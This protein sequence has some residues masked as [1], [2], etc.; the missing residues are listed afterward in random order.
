MRLLLVEDDPMLGDGVSA[1]LGQA[2]FGV[3]WARDVET[4][5]LALKSHHYDGLVLDLGLPDGSGL[6]LLKS[7]RAQNDPIPV[8]ILT[9]RDTLADRVRGLDAGSDDYLVK[10]FELGELTAR[11]R[12]LLRRAHRRA[13]PVLCH[14]EIVVDPATRIVTLHGAP[15]ELPAKEYT[16]LL[17]LL[18]NRGRVLTR[19]QI[20]QSLYGWNAEVESNAIEVH[21]HHLRKKFGADL[22]R[23]L[24][25]VGYTIE[26]PRGA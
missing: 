18:E 10:P 1:G 23:T 9:A 26:K 25:G 14:G 11:L 2:G 21:V 16:L 24:R 20:E 4:S 8:L 17:D 6:D 7:L 3:D 12:A 19:A 13:A 5:R 22:I 15:I